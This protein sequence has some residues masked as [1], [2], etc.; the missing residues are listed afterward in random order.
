[1]KKISL[2]IILLGLS[3][4][5]LPAMDAPDG[6]QRPNRPSQPGRPPRPSRPTAVYYGA[7][8]I[9]PNIATATDA[10]PVQ[11]TTNTAAM[12]FFLNPLQETQQPQ[13]T[14]PMHIINTQTQTPQ[15]ITTQQSQGMSTKERD[16]L[17]KINHDLDKIEAALKDMGW[18][19]GGAALSAAGFDPIGTVGGVG[20]GL[21]RLGKINVL[22][23]R[24]M[25][26][27]QK[28]AK[29]SPEAKA[30]RDKLLPRISKVSKAYETIKG[31]FSSAKEA[32]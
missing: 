28:L 2:I 20:M 11:D 17:A 12:S 32:K 22:L 27:S 1:M 5:L 6:W 16:R 19:F 23:L 24:V 3:T 31:I 7:T 29:A 18:D 30:E 13:I 25:Y 26:T 21:Y 8:P 9:N 10:S 15:P 14:N 4:G